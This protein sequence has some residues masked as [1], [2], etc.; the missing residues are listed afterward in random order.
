MSDPY[1]RQKLGSEIGKETAEILRRDVRDP[2]L[3]LVSITKVDVSSDMRVAKIF[4]SVFGND[5][6]KR[7]SMSGLRHAT[8][9]VQKELGR[10]IRLRVFPEISFVLDESIDKA[11]KIT[12]IIDD[13]A[14]ERQ[15]KAP[16]AEEE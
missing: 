14:R 11:F 5:K 2:R 12:K 15:S 8:G 7:L 6:K 13:L 4:V 10:R 3:G 9:F 1:R 16:G